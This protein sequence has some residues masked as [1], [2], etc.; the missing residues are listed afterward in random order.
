MQAHS[1]FRKFLP[2]V[3]W[4]SSVEV[5]SAVIRLH[6]S[7]KLK[8]AEMKG[9]LSRLGVLIQGWREIVPTDPLRDIARRMLDT[10]D[11]KAADG[12][13]LAAALMWCQQRPGRRNFICTDQR[14]SRAAT[15][16]G[17]SVLD[18]SSVP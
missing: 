10:Y 14:L 6:R 2:V 8:D 1:N 9:A 5:H 4:A 3:W 16:A 17:F 15:A 13:Q 18:L 11:L 7:G 12:L